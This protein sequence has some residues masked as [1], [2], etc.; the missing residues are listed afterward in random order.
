MARLRQSDNGA[1]LYQ[2]LDA[3]FPYMALDTCAT[4]GLCATACP[5]SIDTG[6]LVKRFRNVRASTSAH[7]WAARMARNFGLVERLMRLGLRLGHTTQSSVGLDGMRSLTQ[8]MKRA[9]GE[10]VAEWMPDTP[11]AAGINPLDNQGP[12]AS[13]VL[14]VVH[15][16][17][18]GPPSRRT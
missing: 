18:N 11:Y 1:E 9:F 7:R 14:P 2:S 13:R 8:A 17:R 10:A 4:D 6:Q 12:S 3:E 16:A 5:V 15:F